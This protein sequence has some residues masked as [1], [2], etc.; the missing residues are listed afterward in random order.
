M[1][2]HRT[3]E[4]LVGIMNRLRDPGGCP[5]DRE[6]TYQ[7]LRGYLIEECYE[8]AD[9]I[10][11]KDPMGLREEL[12]DL[13]FQIV[14][15][16]RLG[17]ED[18]AFTAADVVEEI[19]AKMVRR[20]PHVFG[21]DRADDAAAVLK[22][23][24]EIKKEEKA[25]AGTAAAEASLLDGIP[26][27]LPALVAAQRLGTKAARVGFDWKEPADVLA[28]LDEEIGELRREIASG[29]TAD[30][31]G[32]IGDAIFTLVMLAR[33]LNLDAEAALARTNAKFRERFGHVEATL[34]QRGIQIEE[35]GLEVMDRLWEE[36]KG[37]RPDR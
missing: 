22:R 30:A 29:R 11:R 32:E 26:A 4:D 33:R 18:R 24:E 25:A 23:W 16:S 10:D 37:R 28:K 35:A 1:P 31:E 5:W 7:T 8:V 15:L 9:A 2:R 6:Q 14:F 20:H 36:A 17:Q 12:G 19:A 21:D 13:L 27:A 3:F 34:R